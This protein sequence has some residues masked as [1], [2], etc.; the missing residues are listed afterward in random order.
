M[1]HYHT[2]K[3]FSLTLF[4]T[5]KRKGITKVF[6]ENNGTFFV[7]PFCFPDLS[8][9][10]NLL[11]KIGNRLIT[12]NNPPILLILLLSNFRSRY[13]FSFNIQ[14]QKWNNFFN[15]VK[16]I[17]LHKFPQNRSTIHYWVFRFSNKYL[18]FHITKW[19]MYHKRKIFLNCIKQHKSVNYLLE[20]KKTS[21]LTLKIT[22]IN[23][24]NV[25]YETGFQYIFFDNTFYLAVKMKLFLFLSVYL[26]GIFHEFHQ[27]SWHRVWPCHTV[28]QKTVFA[29]AEEYG[30][31][32]CL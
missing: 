21:N 10:E 32:T 18:N 25:L 2:Y 12:W 7:W 6:H 26:F 22:K 5:R 3:G 28:V 20:Y 23:R 8:P 4:P 17:I 30:I 11:Y 15:Q 9:M 14:G 29:E 1:L 19:K 31:D 16:H 27:V 13:N 24:E